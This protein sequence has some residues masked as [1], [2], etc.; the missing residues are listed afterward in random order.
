VLTKNIYTI[1]L[2]KSKTV[3]L[4]GTEAARKTDNRFIPKIGQ[5]IRR[6]GVSRMGRIG[7]DMRNK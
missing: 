2:A 7:N 6:N 5:E 1:G 4:K 3:A